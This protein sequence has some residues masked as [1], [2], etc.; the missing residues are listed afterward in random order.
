MRHVT[1]ALTVGL[2]GVWLI[3]VESANAGDARSPAD[4]KVP[5]GPAVTAAATRTS[6]R[7]GELFPVDVYLS[8]INDL[9]AYQVN[10]TMI[11]GAKGSLT[12]E[13][14]V[15]DKARPNYVFGKDNVI[16]V[17]DKKGPRA[18]AVRSS[19]S[20]NVGKPLYA[21]TFYFRASPDATGAFTTNV[22]VGPVKS[23]L[24]DSKGREIV[25]HTG[26]PATITITGAKR[27]HDDR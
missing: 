13:D 23:M 14:V 16:D 8:N 26:K 6:G 11:G 24:T 15:I 25:V 10:V 20:T 2:F 17:V 9:G 22:G 7:A 4:M 27:A 1:M 18:A 21:A 19:G 5:K 3:G 12:L